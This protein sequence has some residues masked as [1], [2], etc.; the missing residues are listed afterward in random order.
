[1]NQRVPTLLFVI[2]PPAVGKMT[3]GNAIA[4]RTGFRVFHNHLT[5]EPVLR[6]F[7]FGTP[8][9]HRLVESF[10][11]GVLEEVAASDLPGL[12]FTYVWA[13]DHPGDAE[14]VSKYAEPFVRRGGRVLFLELEAS[15]EA[16]LKRNA[17]ADR[18]AEKASKRDL[19]RSRLHL[20]EADDRY[21]L[22]STTEF[23]GRDDHLRVDNTDLTPGEVADL[24]VERL[25]L[26]G[27]SARQS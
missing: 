5:I 19:G 1:M 7:D 4:A 25:S 17:G 11:A 20:L 21:R 12:V 18:L 10:R 22:N 16:R 14:A 15:Q 9:F 24:A 6:F 2:G 3:V 8:P 13:F 23:A 27:R 26:P